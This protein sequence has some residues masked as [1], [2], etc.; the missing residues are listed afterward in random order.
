[1]K[2][3]EKT[4]KR[5]EL[6]G[7]KKLAVR[8]CVIVICGVFCFINNNLLT[9]TEYSFTDSRIKNDF[10]IVQISDLHN[11]RFG[12]D[13]R[14]LIE[15]IRQLSPDIIAVTG[16]IVDSGHTNIDTAV[17]FCQNAAEICPVYYITGNHEHWLSDE[18]EEKLYSG[19]RDSGAVILND[20]ITDISV[21]GNMTELCGL[22]DESLYN[23]TIFKLEKDFDR[24]MPII[25][26]AHEPQYFSDYC[27]AAPDL[28]LTGHA[29]GGQVR[30]P[31]I[32]GLI[33][34][35]QGFFPKY[36]EGEF[37]SGSTH[38]IISRGLGNSVIPVRVFD[39]PEIV[40]VRCSGK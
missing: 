5:S 37:I 19:I 2:R 14:R 1:M 25:L 36:Y 32:G 11:A 4:E 17:S 7:K 33:A 10:T 24:S 23:D 35:D 28:V 6:S 34:P 31:F 22:D 12:K 15:K 29:H 27:K 20:E 3:K 21:N 38:M 13:N 8:L 40:C 26:L 18:D 30:L 16:D 9:V 39:P